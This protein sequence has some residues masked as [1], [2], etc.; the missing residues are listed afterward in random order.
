MLSTSDKGLGARIAFLHWKSSCYKII[1]CNK[2]FVQNASG[3]KQGL[4]RTVGL[5][6]LLNG[7]ESL[8]TH[9]L[10]L[11]PHWYGLCLD[12]I[13][14]IPLFSDPSTSKLTWRSYTGIAF[15]HWTSEFSNK[16]KLYLPSTLLYLMCTYDPSKTQLKLE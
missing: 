7:H 10:K 5:Q 13:D 11:N 3:D 1:L 9:L 8:V 15:T 2:F 16:F 14:N 4:R 6:Y 12:F